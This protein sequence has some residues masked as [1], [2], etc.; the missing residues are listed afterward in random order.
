[1]LNELEIVFVNR[2]DIL[3]SCKSLEEHISHLKIVFKRLQFFCLLIKHEI[4]EFGVLITGH[5]ISYLGILPFPQ[6]VQSII[7]FPLS[8]TAKHLQI[9]LGMVNFYHRFITSIGSLLTPLHLM[10]TSTSKLLTLF[11]GK[12][13]TKFNC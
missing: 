1:M 3:I 4:C 8:N 6:P 12:M 10:L 5:E 2:D 9:F 13:S 7:N 11:L